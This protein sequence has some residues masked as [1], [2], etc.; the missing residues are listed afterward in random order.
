G[1]R[2]LRRRDRLPPAAALAPLL[3]P[4]DPG[5]GARVRRRLPRLRLVRRRRRPVL[6]RRAAPPRRAAD[7]P[8]GRRAA[9]RGRGLP[10]L[11]RDGAAQAARPAPDPLRRRPAALRP[12]VEPRR[13]G[14]G[15]GRGARRAPRPGG[16]PRRGVV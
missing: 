16:P 7:G 4:L 6:V 15:G 5:G 13:R 14:P 2:R 11:R 1:R 9:G 3:R 8:L 10:A 12:R